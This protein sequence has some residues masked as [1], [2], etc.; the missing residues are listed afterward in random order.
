V[1]PHDDYQKLI[2]LWPH[3]QRFQE[4][5]NKHGIHDVFQDNGGKLLQM[6]LITGLSGIGAREGNDAKDLEGREFELKSVNINLT[7]QISTH[8][9]LNPTIL[10]KYRKVRWI[11]AVYRSIEL[12]EI[13]L[14]EAAD[15]EP[16]FSQQEEKWKER[17]GRDL[18]NPKISLKFV[19][20]RG[21]KFFPFAPTAGAAAADKAVKKLVEGLEMSLENGE[22]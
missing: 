6:L 3:V 8:H 5:A 15:L 7:T 9:H 16:W 1:K 12:Q 22:S 11:F 10:G 2:E 17:G 13:W 14:M 20:E 4:L 21:K 19:R 18:N